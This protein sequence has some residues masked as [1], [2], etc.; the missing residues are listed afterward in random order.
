[1]AVWAGLGLVAAGGAGALVAW[2]GLDRANAYLGVPAA[3]AA[4][5]GL[6]VAVYALAA[7]SNP[8]EGAAA[9]R[10]VRQR[11]TS[12]QRGRVVQIGG[13]AGAAVSTS[14]PGAVVD[15]R[16]RA[17]GD[18]QVEQTGGDAASAGGGA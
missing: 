9:P 4:L 14:T 15:Q 5:L 18:G 3:V 13:H 11:A 12:S 7:E 8:L 6:A 1:M 10:R 17:R 2:V 16:A